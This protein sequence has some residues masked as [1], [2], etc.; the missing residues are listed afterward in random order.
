MVNFSKSSIVID[1]IE[2]SMSVHNHRNL[3]KPGT[4]L[5]TCVVCY[6]RMSKDEY[7]HFCFETY[8][9]DGHRVDVQGPRHLGKM[10]RPCLKK[11]CD[12]Y[13]GE[14]HLY[15]KCPIGGCGRA[16]Q[17]RELKDIVELKTYEILMTRLCDAEEQ[18]EASYLDI[19]ALGL[20]LRLCPQCRVRIEKNDGC[21]SMQCYRCGHQFTWSEAQFVKP[22]LAAFGPIPDPTKNASG[23]SIFGWQPQPTGDRRLG[24]A[25]RT[26]RGNRR[27]LRGAGVPAPPAR[28]GVR[29]AEAR[30]SDSGLGGG[31]SAASVTKPTEEDTAEST[32]LHH[33]V[34]QEASSSSSGQ[35]GVEEKELS[36]QEQ[37]RQRKISKGQQEV[38]PEAANSSEKQQARSDG[39]AQQGLRRIDSSDL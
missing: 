31:A 39:E 35:G 17:I 9:V 20:Q 15:V 37:S 11:H 38:L 32:S 25:V 1:V 14:G 7:A 18:D 19:D 5:K 21:D 3:A 28:D 10:C 22:K 27:S 24:Q 34:L 23:I 30:V 12:I 16:L 26:A 36:R 8:H 2:P 4:H 29:E 6:D 33:V 13:L